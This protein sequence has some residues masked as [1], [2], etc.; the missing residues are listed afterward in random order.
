MIGE[1]KATSHLNRNSRHQ[2]LFHNFRKIVTVVTAV[3]EKTFHPWE[4]K[5][6]MSDVTTPGKYLVR[7]NKAFVSAEMHT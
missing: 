7:W 4:E 2:E 3:Y 6:K 5:E 1:V